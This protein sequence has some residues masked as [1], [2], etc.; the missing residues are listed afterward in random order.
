MYRWLSYSGEQKPMMHA[1]GSS[2]SSVGSDQGPS[3]GNRKIVAITVIL[4]MI[5]GA[6]SVILLDLTS[7]GHT[8]TNTTSTTITSTIPTST[9]PTSTNLTTT[10]PPVIDNPIRVA[11][12]DSGINSDSTLSGKVVLGMSFVQTIYGY[13]S[14]DLTVTDA[15]PDVEHGTLVAK[16]VVSQSPSAVIVNAKAIDIDGVAT[17][18]GLIAAIEWAV[19]VNCSV[20]NLSLGS[21]PSFGDTLEQ[22]VEWAHSRGVVVVAAAGNDN[23]DGLM[24]NSINSPS[25]FPHVISVAA[26]TQINTPADYSSR[27]PTV[28]RTMKP[29]IS[30]LGVVSTESATYYGTSF[31]SPRVAGIA[32]ELLALCLTNDFAYTPG[33]IKTALMKGATPLAYPEYEVGAGM[34]NLQESWDL[35]LTNSVNESFCSLTYVHPGELP[36]DYE[37][38]FWGDVY[39]FNIEIING[40]ETEYDITIESDTPTIFDLPSQVIVNQTDYVSLTLHVPL[41]GL[42]NYSARINFSSTELGSHVLEIAFSPATSIA[43]VAIDVSHTTW[44]IDSTYGQFRDLYLTLVENNISVTEINDRNDIT[45]SNL[46]AYDAVLILDPC[47][48]DRNETDPLNP[49]LFSTPFTIAEEQAY[50]DY[51]N[52]GGGIFVAALSNDSLDIGSLNDFLNWTGFSL[53]F[54]QIPIFGDTVEIT[55]I[56]THPITNGIDSF[57]YSGAAIN[58]PVSG[59][60]LAQRSGNSVLGALDGVG[61]FVLSGSNFH[62][63]N[64]GMSGEY[65]SDYNDELALQIV[66]WLCGLL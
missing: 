39:E 6:S 38:L 33:L 40:W 52:A 62:I 57:D 56:F 19:E 14:D 49:E 53:E 31:A 47:V 50:Q 51:F 60:I 46:M 45:L 13:D 22:V 37:R 21:V 23:E 59:E 18:A 64:W 43:K 42:M 28:T 9:I 48:W 63:D 10:V 29:D 65:Y 27:G 2:W 16:T 30:A 7:N 24:G 32:A 66:L 54:N 26:L 58:V 44:S 55:N 17:T 15:S 61:R 12:I 41:V 3:S 35:I 20:I 4:I 25:V 5:I 11:V 34:I 8:S 1:A 36:V